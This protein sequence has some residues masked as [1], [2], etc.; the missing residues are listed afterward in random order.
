MMSIHRV[1]ILPANLLYKL[2]FIFIIIFFTACAVTPTPNATQDIR[3]VSLA[4]ETRIVDE[5][6]KRISMCDSSFQE[7]FTQNTTTTD[8]ISINITSGAS[9]ELR[10]VLTLSLEMQ[11]NIRRIIENF[12]ESVISIT[13]E[14]E[15]MYYVIQWTETWQRGTITDALG[16][17][18]NYEARLSTNDNR[19][20]THYPCPS[21]ILPTDP[22]TLPP[23]T[24]PANMSI[25]TP[26][27][28]WGVTK[29][30]DALILGD[31]Q[32]RDLAQGTRV[33]IIHPEGNDYYVSLVDT[34]E[35]G[36]IHQNL[37]DRQGNCS[38]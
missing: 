2:V 26:S 15:D 8:E 21:A 31:G 14:N 17:A 36:H 23:P 7:T 27:G 9:A 16:I 12:R 13:V 35:T 38:F 1:S 20:V 3:I 22:P 24:P 10:E 29:F 6:T 4:V 33:Y 30:P 19:F 37:V 32:S 28:C 34:N 11:L 18:Y 5:Q 25:P